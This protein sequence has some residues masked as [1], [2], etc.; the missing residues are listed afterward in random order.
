VDEAIH[1]RLGAAAAT[2]MPLVEAMRAHVFAAAS[3]DAA[4][5]HVFTISASHD[6]GAGAPL[7]DRRWV[8]QQFDRTSDAVS[9]SG[10][11]SPLVFT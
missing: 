9:Q 10:F 6:G 11:R 7:L 4:R 3:G 2:L 8:R 5:L 1:A